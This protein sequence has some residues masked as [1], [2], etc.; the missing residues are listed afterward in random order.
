MESA[1][2]KTFQ[3]VRIFSSSAVA[4]SVVLSLIFS[5][6][7]GS[8]SMN[9][10]VAMAIAALAIGIPH[11]A[12]DH[13]V[14]LPR[15]RPLLMS[16][17][18]AAYVGIALVAIWAI[19]KW[20]EAGFIAVVIMSATHF[21]IGDSAFLRELDRHSANRDT[22]LPIWAY[23]IPA[24]VLPV[25]IPLVN[26][27]SA[28]ALEQVN[29]LLVNWDRGHSAEIQI[30][31]AGIATISVLTLLS[32]K[33]YRDCIDIVLLAGLASFTPPLVAFAVYFGCWHA[34]RHTARLTSLLPASIAAH[35]EGRAARAF[36]LAVLPGL[37]ALAGTFI[38][39]GFLA[40]FSRSNIDSDFL[41]LT[42]V[43][44]WALTVPHMIVTAKLDRAALH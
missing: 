15:K 8:Q 7:L 10:Q 31:I 18:I 6:W 17:F 20:N 16:L 39:V 33:R 26:N 23:A 13:L 24:G 34:M 9:W 29:P 4:I 41:W 12:L 1:Q 40:I 27:K 42:L 37:P 25:F 35:Q 21:G 30:L 28:S 36:S 2:K 22:Q 19:L 44:V 32:R 5:S 3:R 11:G 38:F 14:T 43:T